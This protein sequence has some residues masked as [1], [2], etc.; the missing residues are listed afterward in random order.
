VFRFLIP[1]LLLS[2]FVAVGC[3]TGGPC[4]CGDNEDPPDDSLFYPLEIGNRWFYRSSFVIAFYD[5]D[6]GALQRADTTRA[7]WTVSLTGY[8]TIGGVEYATE[9]TEVTVGTD[10]DTT[11]VRLRQDTTG[12]YRADIPRRIRPGDP[13]LDAIT[14]APAELTRLHYPLTAGASW[15]QFPSASPVVVTVEAAD[16]L[17]TPAG[18]QQSWRI[19]IEPPDAGP[20]DH[21]R[22]WHGASGKIQE[23]RHTEVTAID[24]LTGERV[25]IVSD[26]LVFLQGLDL[27]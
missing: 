7:L 19:R 16:T 17:S 9:T 13:A 18:L 6:S 25:R 2:A 8:E 21:H 1:I 20:S 4:G 26:S 15:E 12:L 22:V 11:W 23:D 5:A 27:P 24:D 10:V 14:G 3:G